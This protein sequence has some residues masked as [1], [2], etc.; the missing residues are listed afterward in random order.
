MSSVVILSEEIYRHETWIEQKIFPN[1]SVFVLQMTNC[2]GKIS[3]IQ[4]IILTLYFILEVKLN[5]KHVL[6]IYKSN[7]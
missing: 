4:Y 1:Q 2:F 7:I 6:C 5:Q 3:G